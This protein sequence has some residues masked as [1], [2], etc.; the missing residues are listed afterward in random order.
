MYLW[1][2]RISI[3]VGWAVLITQGPYGRGLAIGMV[4]GFVARRPS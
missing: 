1:F 2:L 3:A 4:L